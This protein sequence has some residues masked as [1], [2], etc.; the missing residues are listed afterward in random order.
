[1]K[2]AFKLPVFAKTLWRDNK[3][4]LI[5]LVLMCTFRSAIADW[6]TVPTGSMKP[7]I[8]EG[9]RIAINKLA[10]DLHL[11][12]TQISLIRLGHPERGDIVVFNSKIAGKRLVKRLIGLPGDVVAMNN[13]HLV[14]NGQAIAYENNKNGLDTDKR[15]DLL[16]VSHSVRIT[17]TNN[18]SF[19]NFPAVTV[20][21]GHYLMLGDNRD[22]SA[23]SR[24]IGFVSREE[25]IG[26]ARNVVMSL[27]YDNYYLPRLDR[28]LKRL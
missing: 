6:N 21:A 19:A 9:D 26:R 2:Q 14:I 12:F 1:M 24:V 17:Q 4:F 25:V 3:L 23:D 8:I 10:Y 5:F 18:H 27:D 28:F 11:P 15:E 7:T 13:N 20:P 16:G 22:N